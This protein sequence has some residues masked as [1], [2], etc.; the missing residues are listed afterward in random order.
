MVLIFNCCATEASLYSSVMV[1]G[2][3]RRVFDG[4]VLEASVELM[5]NHLTI[6]L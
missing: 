4:E 6:S 3:F 5:I 1:G 2:G